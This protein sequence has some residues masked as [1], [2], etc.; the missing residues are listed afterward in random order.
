MYGLLVRTTRSSLNLNRERVLKALRSRL[1]ATGDGESLPSRHRE[2][3]AP[4]GGRNNPRLRLSPLPPRKAIAEEQRERRLPATKPSGLHCN[5]DAEAHRLDNSGSRGRICSDWVL[6]S[7]SLLWV[8]FAGCDR[9]GS[10]T[11]CGSSY[12]DYFVGAGAE[13]S[14]KRWGEYK[15]PVPS[16]TWPTCT[17]PVLAL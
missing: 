11:N 12:C 6:R 16:L 8:L 14:M 13:K 3:P 2:A 7:S 4:P 9:P 17:G 1:N 15:G 5:A 10:L